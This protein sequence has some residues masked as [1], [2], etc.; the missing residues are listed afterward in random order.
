MKIERGREADFSQIGVRRCDFGQI[1][2]VC[3]VAC[4]GD[5]P[6]LL[7]QLTQALMQ[8]RLVRAGEL[9]EEY[10]HGFATEPMIEQWQNGIC[11]C[12]LSRKQPMTESG[13]A[14]E[15]L[16]GRN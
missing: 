11:Q 14:D 3:Q 1:G 15:W 16:K 4:R 9:G 7:P 13:T 12:G 5:D 10:L 8:A 2:Q 6:D